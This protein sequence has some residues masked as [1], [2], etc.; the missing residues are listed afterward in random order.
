M[1]RGVKVLTDQRDSEIRYLKGIVD[2]YEMRITDLEK[3]AMERTGFETTGSRVR[4]TEELPEKEEA[5][6]VTRKPKALR[7]E[8][9]AP[10][11]RGRPPK[12]KPAEELV[13]GVQT[14]D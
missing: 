12:V 5:P 14:I 6:K 4:Y 2:L 8:A 10:K 3:I 11:R 7:P 9:P 13:P 1:P